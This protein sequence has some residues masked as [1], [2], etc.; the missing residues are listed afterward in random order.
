M[1]F[2]KLPSTLLFL[3]GGLLSLI[4]T[5]PLIC[6]FFPILTFSFTNNGVTGAGQMTFLGTR[7]PNKVTITQINGWTFI[8]FAGY[9]V[10]IFFMLAGAVGLFLALNTYHR[11][12]PFESIFKI[13]FN[14]LV[15]LIF[16]LLEVGML[17]LIYVSPVS[18]LNG[19]GF[20]PIS[21]YS[22]QSFYYDNIIGA[23]IGIGFYLLILGSV[24]MVVG[25]IINFVSKPS[26][27][28][29]VSSSA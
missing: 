15:G 26:A 16:G 10:A 11:I 27:M 9:E 12:L 22:L 21:S 4:V 2:K 28:K 18:N 13:P 20:S 3:L 23:S 14:A 17:V 19:W 24:L 8:G 5:I 1:D 29:P 25:A 6:D 7:L